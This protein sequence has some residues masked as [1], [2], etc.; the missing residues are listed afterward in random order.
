MQ[1]AF[2]ELKVKLNS[3]P[4]RGY[5]DYGRPFDVCIQASSKEVE[6]ILSQAYDNG[7]DHPIHYAC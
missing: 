6:A 3:A 4:V 7:R 5:Q 1:I 2:E